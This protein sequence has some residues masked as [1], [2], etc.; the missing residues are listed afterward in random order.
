MLRKIDC[1]MIR[2]DDVPGAAKFYAETFGLRPI[3]H[4]AGSVG[5]GFAETEAEIVIHN[6]PDVP[7]QV[8]V[9]YL[10]DD[11]TA[12]VKIYAQQ[13]CRILVEP[14]DI[15]IGKCAVIADPFGTRLCVLDMTKG[16]RAANL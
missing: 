13:G 11:V 5:L 15:A 10:V 6:S 16:P 7:S 1:V 8:E 12:A 9:H 2:V 14:F 3:W 4:D